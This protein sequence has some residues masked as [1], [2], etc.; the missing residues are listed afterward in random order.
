MACPSAE[1][2]EAVYSRWE[3]YKYTHTHIMLQIY[4]NVKCYLFWENPVIS[5][6]SKN[7]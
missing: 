4:K 7:P 2:E 6:C 3:E 5:I 1:E